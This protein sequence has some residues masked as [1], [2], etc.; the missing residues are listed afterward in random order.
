M[1][2]A[3]RASLVP[4][5]ASYR[6]IIHAMD[7]AIGLILI[8]IEELGIENNTLVM[9][10]SDNGPEIFAG[11]TGGFRDR[12][13]SLHEG[14]IRVPAIFQWVG[15]FPSGRIISSY[16]NMVD[17]FPTFL[18]AVGSP[19]PS[20][21]MLDGVSLLPL[22]KDENDCQLKSPKLIRKDLAKR[23]ASRDTVTDCV[24]NR[25]VFYLNDYEGRRMSTVYFREYKLVLNELDRPEGLYDV[26][27]DPFEQHNLLP[28][29]T[30]VRMK[31]ASYLNMS[32]SEAS[33]DASNW[34]YKNEDEMDNRK[35][36]FTKYDSML[37]HIQNLE[38]NASY[39]HSSSENKAAHGQSI[40]FHLHYMSILISKAHYLLY[41]FINHG[42]EAHEIYKSKHWF[43]KYPATDESS[44]RFL[45][46][47]TMKSVYPV[48]NLNSEFKRNDLFNLWSCHPKQ[49]NPTLSSQYLLR[50]KS[51]VSSDVIPSMV[52]PNDEASVLLKLKT[53]HSSK[54]PLHTS[55][56]CDL[57]RTHEIRP[58]P[59]HPTKNMSNDIKPG[60]VPSVRQLLMRRYTNC[61]PYKCDFNPIITTNVKKPPP[62]PVITTNVRKPQAVRSPYNVPTN[63]SHQKKETNVMGNKK[64]EIKPKVPTS[65]RPR[66]NPK[67]PNLIQ[68][69][70][71]QIPNRI[72]N[73][74][75]PSEALKDGVVINTNPQDRNVSVKPSDP[76][77][78]INIFTNLL[79]LS[80]IIMLFT[81]IIIYRALRRRSRRRWL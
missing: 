7:Y 4:L 45:F 1:S 69:I 32:Y 34:D 8:A 78:N 19:I 56:A 2:D 37:K 21:L 12:K 76:V 15:K 42:N 6:T 27:F 28:L 24:G 81:L 63:T 50:T 22:L 77:M 36:L 14:G 25:F 55:C 11:S 51:S 39:L 60:L 54:L 73:G 57:R 72:V 58:L 17:L 46:T 71:K 3:E 31:Y 43:H 66:D 48:V 70:I 18:D 49:T 13:R 74:P 33:G 65:I 79:Y 67:K 52:Q 41:N 35:I 16:G 20:N 38:F 47:S 26:L 53:F 64:V 59:F 29:Y 68:A 40:T 9:F 5:H 30:N 80:V 75:K 44:T 10:T 62:I 61:L 23:F